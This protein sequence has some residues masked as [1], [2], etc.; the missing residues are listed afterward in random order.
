MGKKRSLARSL[1]IRCVVVSATPSRS[2]FRRA[3]RATSGPSTGVSLFNVFE[4]FING[5]LVLRREPPRRDS[6]A[7]CCRATGETLVFGAENPLNV[8]DLIRHPLSS[9]EVPFAK[10]QHSLPAFRPRWVARLQP[11]EPECDVPHRPAL[12][13]HRADARAV[14]PEGWLFL[15]PVLILTARRCCFSTIAAIVLDCSR[16]HHQLFSR[17]PA[18]VRTSC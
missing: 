2:M 4:L 16:L 18:S 12:H 10:L 7:W 9:F 17:S 1:R 11:F 6:H 5:D 15:I 8:S 13:Y 14:S 3:D